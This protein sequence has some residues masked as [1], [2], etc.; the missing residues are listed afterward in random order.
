M[1]LRNCVKAFA[2]DSHDA[3]PGHGLGWLMIELM[4]EYARQ[5]Q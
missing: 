1:Q 4:I 5:A 3:F 2:D